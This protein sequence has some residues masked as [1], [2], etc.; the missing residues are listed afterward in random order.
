[1]SSPAHS[2]DQWRLSELNREIKQLES[3]V[4][5][6]EQ[7]QQ[8]LAKSARGAAR[9]LRYLRWARRTRSPAASFDLWPIGLL[10][11]GPLFIGFF[12]LAAVELVTGSLSYGLLVFLIGAVAG[13]IALAALLYRPADVILPASLDAAESEHRLTQ[14]KVK[15]TIERLAAVRAELLKLSEERRQLMASGQVQRAALLQRPWK[16][17]TEAEWDD[18]VVEVFRTLGYGIERVPPS[19]EPDASFIAELGSQ[20]IAARTRGEGHV[21]SSNAVQAA[22]AAQNRRQCDRS[23]VIINRR[24]TGAAQDF[25][26]HHDCTLIG[27]EEFPEL[28]MGKLSV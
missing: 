21:V 15:E 24:F 7:N 28:V 2:P 11:L 18:F 14:S 25:A 6:L 19:N 26:R 10:I 9:R 3:D 1:V 27:L 12:L 4:R 17:M 22:I 23:A 20:R 13:A 8:A 16:K 5:Q